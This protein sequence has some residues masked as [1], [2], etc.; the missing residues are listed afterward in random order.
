[1]THHPK[2]QAIQVQTLSHTTLTTLPIPTPSP[3]QLLVKNKYAGINFIDIYQIN[4]TYPT[5]L[6]YIPGQEASGQVLEVG[7]DVEGFCVGDFVAYTSFGTWVEYSTPFY[8]KCVK[9][10][11]DE[12]RIGLDVGAA[13]LIQGLTALTFTN[14]SYVVQKGDFIMVWAAAGGTGRLFCQI[15]N[16]LGAIVIG[17]V[18]SP[19][20]VS[21]AKESGAQHVVLYKEEKVVERVLEITGGRGVDCVYDLVGKTTFDMSLDCLKSPHG[22]LIAVGNASGKVDPFDLLR[23]S[24]GNYRIMRPTLFNY[25]QTHSD[26]KKWTDELIQLVRTGVLK[27]EISKIYPLQ[28]ASNAMDDLQSGKTTGKLLLDLSI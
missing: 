23:L 10:P 2:M 16:H 24:R 9:L 11:K 25:L 4:G 7:R 6:P 1:M 18:G 27:I 3:T 5:S 13:M 8:E 19:S 12:P 14:L 15:A 17:M 28:H 21:L 20:K 26:F 22:T